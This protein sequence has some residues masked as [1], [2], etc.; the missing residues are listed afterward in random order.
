MLVAIAN[1]FGIFL[2]NRYEDI[3]TITV[4]VIKNNKGADFG[5]MNSPIKRKIN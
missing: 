4:E 2:F 3:K 5:W 1:I